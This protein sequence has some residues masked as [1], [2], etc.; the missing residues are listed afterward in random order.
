MDIQFRI[1][2]DFNDELDRKWNL[3][4]SLSYEKNQVHVITTETCETWNYICYEYNLSFPRQGSMCEFGSR[5]PLI[6]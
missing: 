5:A 4:L 3:K 2:Y 1:D 6:L